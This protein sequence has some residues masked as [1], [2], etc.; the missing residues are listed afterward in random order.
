MTRG[1]AT[2]ERV[3]SPQ[4]ILSKKPSRGFQAAAQQR[5]RALVRLRCVGV[6]MRWQNKPT[7]TG[8]RFQRCPSVVVQGS[9]VGGPCR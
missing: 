7:A 8:R 1:H 9:R 4:P 2:P 3:N 5:H 6:V